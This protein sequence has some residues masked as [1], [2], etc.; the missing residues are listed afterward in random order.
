LKFR[1]SNAAP[2]RRKT[3]SGSAR[4]S[5]SPALYDF[6]SKFT[7]HVLETH[8]FDQKSLTNLNAAKAIIR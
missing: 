3:S 2:P 4:L 5:T 1:L 7:T 6:T 8:V